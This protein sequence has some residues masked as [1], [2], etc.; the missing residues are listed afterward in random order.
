MLEGLHWMFLAVLFMLGRSVWGNLIPNVPIDHDMFLIGT[1]LYLSSMWLD[2]DI[3]TVLTVGAKKVLNMWPLEIFKYLLLN[4]I[5]RGWLAWCSLSFPCYLIF[6]IVSCSRD[7][8]G[9]SVILSIGQQIDLLWLGMIFNAPEN[10]HRLS[11]SS[12]CNR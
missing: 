11:N 9:G 1:G 6:F 12:S 2:M 8:S 7:L 10:L 3:G 4:E 5:W